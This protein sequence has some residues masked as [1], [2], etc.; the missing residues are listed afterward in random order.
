[1][2]EAR[3]LPHYRIRHLD[4][5]P[6]PEASWAVTVQYGEHEPA[7]RVLVY[8]ATE[9][10]AM[11]VALALRQSDRLAREDNARAAAAYAEE[12]SSAR[13]SSGRE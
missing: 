7:P 11:R 9:R 8:A 6:L 1:M 3:P 2:S 13:S 5:S 10:V 4:T 12:I